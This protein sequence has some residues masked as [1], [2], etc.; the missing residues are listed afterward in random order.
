MSGGE[1]Q[2][3]AIA[4]ALAMEPEALLLDEPTSAL[5]PAHEA[6]LVATLQGLKGART[7]VLVTHRLESAVACD[8]IFVLDGGTIAERGTHAELLAAGGLY[9]RLWGGRT[10]PA[11]PAAARHGIQMNGYGG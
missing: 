8:R 11:L 5:D 10:P 1:Q 2:R 9:A 7:I 3:C 4:R 6:H